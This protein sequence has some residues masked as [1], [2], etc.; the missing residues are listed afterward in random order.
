MTN[1]P[2][3]DAERHISALDDYSD[4]LEKAQR[5]ME[6]LY[7]KEAKNSLG[8]PSSLSPKERTVAYVMAETIE[9]DPRLSYGAMKVISMAAA[10]I[11]VKSLANV[12]L[13]RMARQYAKDNAEVTE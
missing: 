8:T 4:K 6:S 7:L 9:S 5:E 11:S 12:L 3:L 10:G 1:D 13:F 2:V